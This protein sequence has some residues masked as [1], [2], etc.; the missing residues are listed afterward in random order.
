MLSLGS[1]VSRRG[2]SQVWREV[3]ESPTISDRD[4]SHERE[5]RSFLLALSTERSGSNDSPA[6]GSTQG[7]DL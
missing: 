4:E 6:A 2:K 7:L 3:R 1:G 5:H